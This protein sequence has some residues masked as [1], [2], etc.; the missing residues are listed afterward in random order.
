MNYKFPR[1]LLVVLMISIGLFTR[2]AFL[3]VITVDMTTYLLWYDYIAQHGILHTLGDQVFGYNPPFIYLLSIATL[4]RSFLPKLWAIKLISFSFDVLNAGLVYRIVKVTIQGS[5]APIMAALIFWIAPTLMINSAVWG[6]T[7]A[8]YVSFLLLSLLLLFEERPTLAVIAFAVA[9]SIKAQGIFLAPLLAVLLIKKRVVWHTFLLVPVVYILAFIPTFFAGRPLGSLLSTYTAQ[10]ETFLSPSKN[11]PNFY[12]F[13][14]Q[15]AYEASVAI[16]IPLAGLIL[17]AWVLVF[18]TKR[19]AMTKSIL[20]VSGLAAVALTPFVLPKMHDRYFYPADVF[21]LLTA[22][23]VPGTWFVPIAYQV[24]SL[25][26]YM[27]YL[28]G[29][30]SERVIP[31]A[32][33]VNALT[34][35]FLVWKQWKLISSTSVVDE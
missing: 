30:P 3:P 4:T 33:I 15:N 27:P 31:A 8:I 18:G 32:V 20:M 7:D 28:F 2:L 14:P 13:L 26:A 23:I 17:L 10:G 6:Q 12:F 21:S 5:S 11:A 19:Y 1:Y 35:T 16:G 25:L 34:I 24:I 9:I 22:F 29:V